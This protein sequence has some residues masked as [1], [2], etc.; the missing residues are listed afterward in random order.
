MAANKKG[1][2]DSPIDF[3]LY[4]NFDYCDKFFMTYCYGEGDYSELR[5]FLIDVCK[6]HYDIFD[7]TL[8]SYDIYEDTLNALGIEIYVEDYRVT[9]MWYE[10]KHDLL[11][12]SV[13]AYHVKVGD[14]YIEAE[15]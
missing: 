11:W 10:S 8:E 5:R 14:T 4:L 12:L 6:T 9:I 15:Y 7:D 2:N 13:G 3:P 1:S